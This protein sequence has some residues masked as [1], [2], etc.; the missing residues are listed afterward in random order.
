MLEI[1]DLTV[2]AEDQKIL[3]NFNIDIKD[4]EIH[5]IMGK[6]G[7]GKSTI[8]KVLL[9]DPNYNIEHGTIIFDKENITYLDTDKIAQKGI[10]LLNQTPIAIPGVSNSECLRLALSSKTNKSV[11]ILKFHQE[12]K[13]I[14][15]KLNIPKE[16]I[17]RDINAGMSGGERKKNELMHLWMLKPK[18]IILDE[19]DSGLD[20]DSFKVVM[21]S[22]KDYYQEYH[23]TIL[24]ITHNTKVFKYLKP[25]KISILNNGT[26]VKTGDDS[27]IDTID[28]DGFETFNVSENEIYE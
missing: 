28:K 17:H 5:A 4:Q 27:L 8:C 19:V 2:T 16:F 3:K 15:Q 11:D 24:I 18:F 13:S 1:K 25:D 23:P 12:L 21:K 26:I 22:L 7:A 9:N 6:N 20:V 10:F 14:C